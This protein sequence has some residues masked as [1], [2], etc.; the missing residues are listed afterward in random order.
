MKKYAI[1]LLSVIS[2]CFSVVDANAEKLKCQGSDGSE[3]HISKMHRDGKLYVTISD[4][5]SGKSKTYFRNSDAHDLKVGEV[6]DI[7]RA[8][9]GSFAGTM[10][11]INDNTYERTF[12]K[13]EAKPTDA[14]ATYTCKKA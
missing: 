5:A 11:K 7:Y 2:V 10:R 4:T 8:V 14:K 3:T 1:S 12:S 6:T 9:D 13:G